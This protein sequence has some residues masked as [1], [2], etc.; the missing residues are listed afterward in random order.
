M[1]EIRKLEKQIVE[2]QN[3]LCQQNAEA[4]KMRDKLIDDN[5]RALK[6]YQV[7]M[8]NAL[9]AR[10][11]ATRKEYERKLYE[12]QTNLMHD[13]TVEQSEAKVKYELLKQDMQKKEAEMRRKSD[14]LESLINQIKSDEASRNKGNYE[15]ADKHINSATE[16]LGFIDEKPHRKFMPG[17]VQTYIN[18]I[19]SGRELIKEKMFEAAAAVGIMAKSG[20]ELLGYSIDDKVSVWEK[21]YE[22]FVSRLNYLQAKIVQEYADWYNHIGLE[23]TQDIQNQRDGYTEINF[24]SNGEF[25]KIT[26]IAQKHQSIVDDVSKLGINE[27]LKLPDSVDL[28]DLKHFTDEIGKSDSQLTV[29]SNLYKNRYDASVERAEWGEAIINFLEN[30]INLIWL[31]DSTGFKLVEEDEKNS[32]VFMDFTGLQPDIAATNEDLRQWLRLIFRNNSGNITI[33]IYILPIESNELVSNEVVVHIDF[34][35]PEQHAFSKEINVHIREAIGIIDESECIIN[36]TPDTTHLIINE[37]K[38]YKETGKDIER[39]KYQT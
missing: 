30:E 34:N 32:A 13:V 29:I 8:N 20:L 35:G 15:E 36:Y 28:D 21:Q 5:R 27:Y 33:F 37:K 17:S 18:K 25:G 23:E 7:D 11:D 16:T 4:G 2:L 31:A 14:E 24:W 12:Y 6:S 26:G 1:D 39:L 22:V 38:A 3:Q 19:N 10:D 9:K